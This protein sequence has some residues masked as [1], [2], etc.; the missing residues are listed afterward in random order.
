MGLNTQNVPLVVSI[1]YGYS[2]TDQCSITNCHGNTSQQ[3]VERTNSEFMKI[4]L[5]GVSLNAASG[6]SGA[7][8]GNRC[9]SNTPLNPDYPAASPALTSV[10]ATMLALKD[11]G[12]SINQNNNHN[13]NEVTD[14][15]PYCDKH[16]WQKCANLTND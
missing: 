15:P 11:Q 2:E 5:R 4:G 14:L 13:Q 3:Y 7:S 9:S 12:D 16:F 8:G 1:S 10:G 6:D